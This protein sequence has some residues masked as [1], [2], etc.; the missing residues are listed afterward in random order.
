MN[1]SQLELTLDKLQIIATTVGP[2]HHKLRWL[3]WW[4]SSVHT[5]EAVRFPLRPVNAVHLNSFIVK[6]AWWGGVS[7]S[8]NIDLVCLHSFST[9]ILCNF[10]VLIS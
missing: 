10:I 9:F 6:A 3:K 4:N 7:F 5:R 1:A 2:P 8:I